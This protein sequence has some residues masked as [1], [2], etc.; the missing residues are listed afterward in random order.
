MVEQGFFF[1]SYFPPLKPRYILW[2]DAS[3]SKKKK[4]VSKKSDQNPNKNT[5]DI[6]TSVI[7]VCVIC[8]HKC[9]CVCAC[10]VKNM[11]TLK[12]MNESQK[13]HTEEK[14]LHREYVLCDCVFKVLEQT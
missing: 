14:G 7:P 3:Y 13:Q 9:L 1:F 2:S 11:S 4:T 12:N 5:S 10:L 6:L 8:M